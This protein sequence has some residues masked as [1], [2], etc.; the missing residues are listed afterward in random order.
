M[1]PPGG[2]R[3]PSQPRF[4]HLGEA[5]LFLGG[6]NRSLLSGLG[7]QNRM[8]AGGGGAFLQIP[9]IRALE[10]GVEKVHCPGTSRC[11]GGTYVE[12][13]S[14]S[15]EGAPH[16]RS[17]EGMRYI[18]TLLPFPAA[19]NPTFARAPGACGAAWR[20]GLPAARPFDVLRRSCDWTTACD[21]RRLRWALVLRQPQRQPRLRLRLPGI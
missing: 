6:V 2:Q 19:P 14:R 15:N 18:F 3:A 7:A 1:T 16:P 11:V 5:L 20:R 12:A 4:E 8:R 10:A 9:G 21:A 13:S 17:S